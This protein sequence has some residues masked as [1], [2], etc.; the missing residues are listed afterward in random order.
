[1][2]RRCRVHAHLAAVLAGQDHLVTREQALAM[3]ITEASIQHRIRTRQWRLVLPNVYLT[4]AGE[5]TQR[6]RL[7]AALLHAG[8]SSA[9]D[10]AVACRFHGIESVPRRDDV[11][12][13]VPMNAPARS[14]GFVV[15][16]R[17]QAPI[18]TVDTQLLR[19]V[20]P[21]AAAVAAA[22]R[23]R[24]ERALLA[25]F[26]EVLQRRKTSYDALVRAHL[27]GPPRGSRLAGVVLDDL[28]KGMRSAPEVDFGRLAAA[29]AI[30]PTPLFNPLIRL[31]SGELISPDALIVDA[32]LVH[33]TNGQ[34][35]HAREDRF[36]EMHERHDAMT[37]A[38]LT[39]LHNSPRRLR[40]EGRQ[41]L[42]QLE[43]CY[44]RLAG[45]GLPPG[46]V[47]LRPG[48]PGTPWLVPRDA[49]AG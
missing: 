5:A 7:V 34:R 12:V 24:D 41:A 18:R 19:Y 8:P 38:G 37:T 20:E 25:L 6:Q 33:E 22:R 16:R 31:P 39:V 29:S 40:R 23:M 2:P 26:S 15:V 4:H 13:V 43:R 28:A 9:I 36:D 49:I 3:G 44:L 17:T 30:L 45:Q 32:G 46:V 48:P 14:R 11:D 1:M 10:A 21:A 27:E 35:H 42:T 47:M